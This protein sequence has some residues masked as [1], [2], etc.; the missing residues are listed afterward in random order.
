MKTTLASVSKHH[1]IMSALTIATN[2]LP[3]QNTIFHSVTNLYGYG[4]G[5]VQY[6]FL[7]V[8]NAQNANFTAKADHLHP[9]I[10]VQLLKMRYLR[11]NVA[12]LHCL[13]RHQKFLLHVGFFYIHVYDLHSKKINFKFTFVQLISFSDLHAGIIENNVNLLCTWYFYLKI[14]VSQHFNI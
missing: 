10:T 3:T 6:R 2:T 1:I 13:T 11:K 7:D 14:C 12:C 4:I 9:A 8:Y 5:K